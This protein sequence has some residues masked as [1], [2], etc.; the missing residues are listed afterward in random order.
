M[1]VRGPS[2]ARGVSAPRHPDGRGCGTRGAPVVPR[3]G[4]G[5]VV[6]GQKVQKRKR[7]R[8]LLNVELTGMH[9]TA[10]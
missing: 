8:G 9:G 2:R 4:K 10:G 6:E 5:I 7:K 3:E 1:L